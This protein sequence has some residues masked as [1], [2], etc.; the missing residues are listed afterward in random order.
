MASLEP[1]PPVEKLASP[2]S[3]EALIADQSLIEE[4]LMS[5]PN[6]EAIT[7]FGFVYGK[8]VTKKVQ[9]LL[10]DSTPFQMAALV[11]I[12]SYLCCSFPIFVFDIAIV[13]D[14]HI[15][16]LYNAVLQHTTTPTK[17]SISF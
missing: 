8:V 2:F 7:S 4:P 9:D 1:Q 13:V 3:L 6:E 5:D 15:W 16:R 14:E 10:R 17:P 11:S 12:H